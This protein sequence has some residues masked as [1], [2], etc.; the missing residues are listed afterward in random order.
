MH[1]P[2]N[3]RG[4]LDS[5]DGACVLDVEAFVQAH[6]HKRL[7]LTADEREDLVAEGFVIMERLF[8]QYE[9]GR[10]GLDPSLSKFS[11]FAAALLPGKLGDAWHRLQDNHRMQTTPEGE[12]KW[13]YGEKP[14]SLEV[15]KEA[16]IDHIKALQ[17][18]DIYDSDMA[19]ALRTVLDDR[20]P[21]D[22]E[23]TVKLA[24][25]M[26]C[27]HSPGEAARV[28]GISDREAVLAIER[29]K[30]VRGT[31]RRALAA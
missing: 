12:R 20:W 16:G 30:A 1:D 2:A 31:L 9:P 18:E 26:G 24:V 28:L 11:G 29:I 10:N 14:T 22:R 6:I 27:D 19:H 3:C 8:R 7:V 17:T 15:V 13:H 25:L 4:A 21:H 23:V 5:E